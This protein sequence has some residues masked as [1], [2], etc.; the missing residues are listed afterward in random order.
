MNEREI[1]MNDRQACCTALSQWLEPGT[2]KALAEPTR[3]ALL[4]HMAGTDGPH[5][6]T[7]LAA[8]LP[9]DV[10]VV[11]RHLRLLREVGV[12]TA[13]RKGKEM[14]HRLDC[15]DL[16]HMLRNL[17]DALE[18]CCPPGGGTCTKKETT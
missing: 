2:F 12:V 5:T 14:L 8:R 6:V 17:A 16:I 4:L 11:S 18:S 7:G 15:G 13:E 10:S 9:V 1:A 3:A